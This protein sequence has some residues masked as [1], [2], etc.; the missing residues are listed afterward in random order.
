MSD[1]M[2]EYKKYLL[3]EILAKSNCSYSDAL[4]QINEFV[5]TKTGIE[6][7]KKWVILNPKVEKYNHVKKIDRILYNIIEKKKHFK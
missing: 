7:Y 4:A 1:S 3:K 6:A 2:F 5:K